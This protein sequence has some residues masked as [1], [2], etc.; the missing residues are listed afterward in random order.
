MKRQEK[1][2]DELKAGD[3][4][5]W[6]GAIEVVEEYKEYPAPANEWY[7]NEKLIRFKLKPYNDEAVECLGSYYANG[8]YGGV[9]CLT[10]T[11]LN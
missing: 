6:H 2:Y 4:I 11:V 8:T 1:R 10:V 9:G 7:P 5:L 3:I